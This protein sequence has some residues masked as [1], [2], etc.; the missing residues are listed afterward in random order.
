[1]MTTRHFLCYFETY[2]LVPRTAQLGVYR[3]TRVIP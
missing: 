3:V 1:M 2:L